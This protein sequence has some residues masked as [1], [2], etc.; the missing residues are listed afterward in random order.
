MRAVFSDYIHVYDMQQANKDGDTDA[1]NDDSRQAKRRL[2][3]EAFLMQNPQLADAAKAAAA[4]RSR[5]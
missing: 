3:D 2:K 5:P 1:I 4:C